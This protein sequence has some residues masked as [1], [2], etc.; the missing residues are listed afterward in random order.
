M[1]KGLLTTVFIL[2]C[3]LASAQKIEVVEIQELTTDL[4]ARIRPRTDLNGDP[5]ALLKI[6]MPTIDGIEFTGNVVGTI[7]YRMGVYYV[8]VAAG[9]KRLTYQHEHYYPG[10]IDFEKAGIKISPNTTYSIILEEI[11][12]DGYN[13]G[14]EEQPLKEDVSS[15][16]SSE[17]SSES[18]QTPII[19]AAKP[20]V[21]K[22]NS[23][24]YL[25]LRGGVG[26]T[27]G[28]TNWTDL[29]SPAADLS[30]G[31]QFSPVFGLRENVMIGQGRGAITTVTTSV[32]KFN[33]A[34]FALDATFDICNIFNVNARRVLN[35]Y[36][37]VGVGGNARFN[38]VEAIALSQNFDGF[39]YLWDGT[40]ISLAGRAGVGFDIRLSDAIKLNLE[41]GANALS[42]HFNSKKTYGSIKHD[43]LFSGLVG[44]KITF[45][46]KP[47]QRQ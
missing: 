28:E 24:W 22:F 27:I 11:K 7:I 39:E 44:V 36:V 18:V 40:K 16:Y 41:G 26:E 31:Y 38:N 30:I 9:T 17:T 37:Y 25:Q 10:V 19:T 3:I 21:P 34:Q 33:F 15:D 20:E 6:A 46:K 47:A 32:Y 14:V 5:C 42:D 35:P 8:Y 45:D 1:K 12:A 13:S 29:L 4:E 23:C 43:H 2:V